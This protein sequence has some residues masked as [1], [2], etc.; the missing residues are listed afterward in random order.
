M[1]GGHQASEECSQDQR[2][3]KKK[4]RKDMQQQRVLK[5]K[6]LDDFRF[7]IYGVNDGTLT[8]KRSFVL[9]SKGFQCFFSSNQITQ[10]AKVLNAS[11]GRVFT[12]AT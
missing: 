10:N 1:R 4:F 8:S 12:D 3:L 2:T 9:A 7:F 6:L 5:K 11:S